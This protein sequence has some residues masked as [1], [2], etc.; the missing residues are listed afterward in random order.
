MSRTVR[1]TGYGAPDVLAIVETPIPRPG[2]G[3]VVVQ[4]KAAGVNPVDWKLYSGVFHDVD[5]EHKD[6]AGIDEE[7]LPQIGLEC[8]GVV[9]AV[10]DDVD[11]STAKI[12]D[13]VIVYPVNAAY[14]DYVV[15]PTTSLIPKPESLAW[16]EA[17]ALMLSGTTAAHALHAAEVHDGDT[18]LIH[19]GTGGVGLV[20]IQLAAGRGAS[21]IATTAEANFDLLLSL[22][23]TP[24]TYGP[25]LLDRV[26]AAAPDG[27]T[28][29]LDFIGT[30][31]ALD[32]SLAVVADR[33]RIVS[34][35]GGPRC[36]EEGI[37]T[38]GYGPGEDMG[39]E[40]REAARWDL[41]AAAGSDDLRVV[42]DTTYPLDEAAKA[43]SAGIAGHA[44]GKLVLIP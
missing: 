33:K 15:V 44:P 29:A 40:V 26:R 43:H 35:T 6:S 34:I 13:D 5:D 1:P 2:H 21:V 9:T 20:A 25:G 32:T 8:A 12:G 4:V 18:V 37:K 23:A 38:L 39:T 7:S 11:A 27:V 10:S 41:V 22:G 24:V 28:A 19:N 14:A 17:G 16:A 42:V 36:A 30:E 3:Q 31:E